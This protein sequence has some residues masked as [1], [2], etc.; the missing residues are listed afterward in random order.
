MSSPIGG[1]QVEFLD[2][3]FLGL[4]RHINILSLGEL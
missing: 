3:G 1:I 4:E 2:S